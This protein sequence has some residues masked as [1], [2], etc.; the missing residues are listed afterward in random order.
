VTFLQ[1]VVPGSCGVA[2]AVTGVNVG[3]AGFAVA[4]CVGFTGV[5]VGIRVDVAVG[6]AVAG[7]LVAVAGFGVAVGD[8][9]P[10]VAVG[11]GTVRLFLGVGEAVGRVSGIGP[12]MVKDQ[13]LLDDRP[14]PP[15]S[16]TFPV[17]VAV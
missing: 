16:L 2:V 7:T 5:A 8:V 9:F 1:G 14:R 10:G 17:M 4:V 11:V 13:L 15:T 3:D 12:T 6:V